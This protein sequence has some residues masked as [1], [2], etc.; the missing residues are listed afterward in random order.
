MTSPPIRSRACRRLRAAALASRRRPAVRGQRPKVSR[1]VLRVVGSEISMARRTARRARCRRRLGTS[2]AWARASAIWWAVSGRGQLVREEP[3]VALVARHGRRREPVGLR[4]GDRP[5][6]V[7]QVVLVVDEMPR[8]GVE[9]LG[10]DRRVGAAHVVGRVDQSLAEELRP[11]PV[12]RGPGEVGIVGGRHPGGQ[13]LARIVLRGDRRRPCR[14]A[15]A[16]RRGCLV[17]R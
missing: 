5:D 4:D 9:Q 1:I 3:R 14:R 13:R 16:A 2:V 15:A 17:R 10:M 11:D 7:A 12:G 6:Q 8:Q